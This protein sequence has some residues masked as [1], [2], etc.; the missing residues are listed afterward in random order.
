MHSESGT[1]AH[2]NPISTWAEPVPIQAVWWPASTSEPQVAGHDRV[3]VDMVAVVASTLA[4]SPHDRLVLDAAEFEVIGA[5]QNW[6]RGPGRRAG[7]RLL[8]L[9]RVDG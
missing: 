9:R 6:D 1:D 5:A 4:V 2:G 8:D 7:R 3:V